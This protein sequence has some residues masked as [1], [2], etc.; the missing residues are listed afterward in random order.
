[1]TWSPVDFVANKNRGQFSRRNLC[2]KCLDGNTCENFNTVHIFIDFFS[3]EAVCDI[4]KIYKFKGVDYSNIDSWKYLFGNFFRY[5]K[6]NFLT[7][8]L[9]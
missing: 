4:H 5:N 8:L 2:S 7:V 6:E 9:F 3:L 1:M